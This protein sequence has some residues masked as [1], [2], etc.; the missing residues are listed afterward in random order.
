ML[1]GCVHCARGGQAPTDIGKCNFVRLAWRRLAG[2]GNVPL[3]RPT[4]VSMVRCAYSF[5]SRLFFTALRTTIRHPMYRGLISFDISNQETEEVRLPACTADCRVCSGE[6]QSNYT[7]HWQSDFTHVICCVIPCV[8]PFT[9]YG[10][11]P[12][13]GIGD[14]SMDLAMVPRISRCHNLQFM[15]KVTISFNDRVF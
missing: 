6:Q 15:R 10:L 12:F 2:F 11:A 8:S 1:C 3:H 13:A 4:P 14:G 5:C 9:P 7:F